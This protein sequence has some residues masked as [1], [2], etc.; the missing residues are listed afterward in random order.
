M[1]GAATDADILTQYLFDPNTRRI[2]GWSIRRLDGARIQSVLIDELWTDAD[3]LA[4]LEAISA[5]SE[6][7][8][9]AAILSDPRLK[10]I[11]RTA[12]LYQ[13]LLVIG[14]TQ[15]QRQHLESAIG[16]GDR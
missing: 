11:D 13:A 12:P 10:A 5:V 7:D 4:R 14:L 15:D 9:F 6:D 1:L 16:D 8:P 2:A 3:P